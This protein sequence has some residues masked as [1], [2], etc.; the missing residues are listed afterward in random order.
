MAPSARQGSIG[1]VAALALVATGCEVT[2]TQE[3]DDR[4]TVKAERTLV[5]PKQIEVDQ[6]APDVEIGRTS[7]VRGDRSAAI[8]VELE[9]RG[10]GI[11]NDLPIAVGIKGAKGDG[12]VNLDGG[13]RYFQ[14]HIP[15]LA[16]GE[17]ATWVFSTKK[18]VP[19]GEPFA[20]VGAPADPPLT[21]ADDLPSIEATRTLAAS[22]DA[23]TI[24]VDVRNAS[25]IPQ[26][27]VEIYASAE[28]HGRVVAA[29]TASIAE[30]DGGMSDSV[31]VALVGDPGDA[32]VDVFVPPTI[33][34]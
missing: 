23:A 3:K 27:D 30:L 15:A 14:S 2:T 6:S 24:Q 21:V 11:V 26:Y 29:G 5:R 16:P 12:Y 8:A 34:K 1:L 19:S 25:D 33:F 13:I 7:I 22:K 28:H 32:A 9:N 17:K 20:K 18:D 10:D 31:K 4:L